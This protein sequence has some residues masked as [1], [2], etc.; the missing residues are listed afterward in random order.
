[1]RSVTS[2]L[3]NVTPQVVQTIEAGLNDADQQVR[4][5]A[6][7]ALSQS[8]MRA[9]VNADALKATFRN[10]PSLMNVLVSRLNDN[11]SV[12]RAIAVKTL[13]FTALPTNDNIETALVS[14]YGD[15]IDPVVKVEILQALSSFPPNTDHDR[16]LVQALT[17]ASAFL[18]KRGAMEVSKRHLEAALPIIADELRSGNE[19]TRPEFVFAL[20]S[21]GKQ[22]KPY[23]SLLVNL[24]PTEIRPDIRRQIEAAL[25]AIDLAN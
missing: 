22:A 10:R 15:D 24:L 17:D 20:Q 6:A 21:Y 3:D 7:S 23:R 8:M 1:M 5:I 13:A 9:G 12:I 4:V 11:D 14:R 16:I 19:E 25:Q 2:Q 18:R